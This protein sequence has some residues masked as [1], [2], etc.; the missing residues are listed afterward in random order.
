[1]SNS[2]CLETSPGVVCAGTDALTSAVGGGLWG[3]RE[4]EEK[5]PTDRGWVMGGGGVLGGEGVSRLVRL[6]C[7][8]H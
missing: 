8:Q 7:V 1:M 6:V 3:E 2:A 4:R 5:K